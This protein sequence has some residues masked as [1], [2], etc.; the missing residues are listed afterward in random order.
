LLTHFYVKVTV[1]L[2]Y[3]VNDAIYSYFI[4]EKIIQYKIK[5]P[6]RMSGFKIFKI[7]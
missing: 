3:S 7:I 2:S 4:T 6:E 1:I 5:K